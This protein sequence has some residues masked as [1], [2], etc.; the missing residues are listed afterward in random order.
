MNRFLIVGLLV[1]VLSATAATRYVNKSSA[2]PQSPFTTKAT[3]ARSIAPAVAVASNGD[4]ILVAT[5]TYILASQ[6]AVNKSVILRASGRR[7]DTVVDGDNK[8][9]CFLIN[10]SGARLDG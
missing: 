3:A 10:N 9:R 4:T 6:V 5:G 1:P 8:T 7:E 2:N